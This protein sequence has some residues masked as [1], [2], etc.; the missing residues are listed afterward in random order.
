ML[1]AYASADKDIKAPEILVVQIERSC[2]LPLLGTIDE[3]SKKQL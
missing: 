2:S 3:V 1:L